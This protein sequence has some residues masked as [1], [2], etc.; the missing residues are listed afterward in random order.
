MGSLVKEL[1]YTFPAVAVSGVS[2]TE[3]LALVKVA[4]K[5][6]TFYSPVSSSVPVK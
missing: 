3:L 4:F 1:R 2:F 6:E 5:L